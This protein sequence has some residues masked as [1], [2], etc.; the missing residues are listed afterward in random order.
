ML[1]PKPN[2]FASDSSGACMCCTENQLDLNGGVV[3][4]V[5]MCA[6]LIKFN[7]RFPLGKVGSL[8]VGPVHAACEGMYEGP[9][10]WLGSILQHVDAVWQL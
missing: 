7:L 4:R 3:V 10:D 8:F 2:A 9:E 5:C 6:C 1:G